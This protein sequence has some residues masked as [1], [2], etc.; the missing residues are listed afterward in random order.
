M[1]SPT[2]AMQNVVRQLK[3]MRFKFILYILILITTASCRISNKKVFEEFSDIHIPT[4]A[5]VFNDQYQVLGQD[6]VKIL[7]LKLDKISKADLELS[8]LKSKF[9]NSAIYS[10]KGILES[11]QLTI[12]H[13]KGL[14]YR[15]KN[16]YSF[17]GSANN[18]KDI[19]TV[20]I[21][22]LAMNA[23]FKFSAD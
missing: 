15:D 4:T 21:D 3:P 12:D 1:N 20:T 6:F 10:D 14:W 18:E 13:K 5:K 8:I 7:E 22:T 2:S 16:G 23:Q 17:Y 19:V 9:F 11:Q